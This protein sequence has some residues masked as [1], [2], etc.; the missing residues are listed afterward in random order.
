M[1]AL[2][3]QITGCE[4][5]ERYKRDAVS[6]L[7]EGKRIRLARDVSFQED[8]ALSLEGHRK[9]HALIKHLLVGHEGR[10]CPAGDRPIVSPTKFP[11]KRLR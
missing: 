5:L 8:A 2:M 1:A 7:G 4:E 11:R 9:V 10:P 6:A 3:T